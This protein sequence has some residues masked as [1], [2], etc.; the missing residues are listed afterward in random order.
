MAKHHEVEC[1]QVD[2][3]LF[4]NKP[5]QKNPLGPDSATSSDPAAHS[6]NWR[7][8]G[9]CASKREIAATNLLLRDAKNNFERT[10]Y[11]WMSCLLFNQCIFEMP[12]GKCY[13]SLGFERWGALAWELEVI[14]SSST[15]WFKY[16]R[17]SENGKVMEQIFLDAVDDRCRVRCIPTQLV[18]PSS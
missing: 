14:E 8:A 7:P 10:Q 11:S 4:V 15:R 2:T 12:S 1:P 13:I 9:A 5:G 3:S 17:G 16:S 18:H 6:T